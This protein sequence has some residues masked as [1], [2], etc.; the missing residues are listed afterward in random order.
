MYIVIFHNYAPEH[1]FELKQPEIKF[2]YLTLGEALQRVRSELNDYGLKTKW[3]REDEHLHRTIVYG[4]IGF[5]SIV[6]DE[7]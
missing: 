7:E 4:G 1:E 6:K 2:C 5:W 3:Q